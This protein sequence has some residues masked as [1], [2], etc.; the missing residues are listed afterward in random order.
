MLANNLSFEH[1]DLHDNVSFLNN[2]DLDKGDGDDNSVSG[3]G[4]G[5]EWTAEE[6]ERFLKQIEICGTHNWKIVAEHF[7]GKTAKQ[8]RQRWHN[9]LNPE[10]KRSAWS[11]EEDRILLHYHNQIGNKWARIAKVLKGRTDNQIKNR[12]YSI[13]RRALQMRHPINF[14]LG[15]QPYGYSTDN[16]SHYSQS[17]F[18]VDSNTN[19]NTTTNTTVA[20]I[21]Q[22][23][24]DSIVGLKRPTPLTINSNSNNNYAVS[25]PTQLYQT[26]T[27]DT[28]PTQLQATVSQIP[29]PPAPCPPSPTKL[30][31][32]ENKTLTSSEHSDDFDL[33]D[34]SSLL[35]DDDFEFPHNGKKMKTETEIN[36][37]NIKTEIQQNFNNISSYPKEQFVCSTGLKQ[38]PGHPYL[39]Y[40][41]KHPLFPHLQNA[42]F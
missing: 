16:Q 28:P 37:S 32:F 22:S 34:W 42:P 36:F 7:P 6:D 9:H 33:D 3:N 27:P 41:D 4:S 29:S 18:S 8:C 10:I 13:S 11:P 19:T 31:S 20:T 35:A 38:V 40:D 23:N 15:P 30:F 25:S 1:S 14:P 39:Y 21:N 17:Q 24:Y 2:D 5:I 12:F 26:V